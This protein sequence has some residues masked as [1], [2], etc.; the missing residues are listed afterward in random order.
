[1]RHQLKKKMTKNRLR[2]FGVWTHTKKAT[3]N[4]TDRIDCLVFTQRGEGDRDREGH[5][6]KLLRW[7]S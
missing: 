5:W 1:M 2:W 4:T 7:I 6:R 3:E